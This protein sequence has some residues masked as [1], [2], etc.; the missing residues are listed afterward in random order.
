MPFQNNNQ[1]LNLKA[2]NATLFHTLQLYLN[3]DELEDLNIAIYQLADDCLAK[4][5][6]PTLNHAIYHVKIQFNRFTQPISK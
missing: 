3:L 5:A 4:R 2:E 6:N 1:L